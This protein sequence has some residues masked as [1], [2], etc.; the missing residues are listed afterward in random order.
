VGIR[1]DIARSGG[2]CVMQAFQTGT[3]QNRASASGVRT[4]ERC[5][6]SVSWRNHG[7]HLLSKKPSCGGRRLAAYSDVSQ[8][9]QS[10]VLTP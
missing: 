3:K 9:D 8:V 2:F 5:V 7:W 1:C 6:G 4:C 10:D